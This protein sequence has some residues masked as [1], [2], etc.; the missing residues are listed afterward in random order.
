MKTDFYS[1]GR[2]SV[3]ICQTRSP[4]LLF[5][6][7]F[8][9]S[10]LDIYPNFHINKN[11]VM[12]KKICT[13]ILV[14]FYFLPTKAQSYLNESCAWYEFNGDVVDGYLFIS[15]RWIQGDTVMNGK[16]YWKLYNFTEYYQWG[17]MMNNLYSW[18][19]IREEDGAFYELVGSGDRFIISFDWE[20]GDTIPAMGGG[21][22]QVVAS[23]ETFEVAGEQR[24]KFITEWGF[25]IYEG[26]GTN[27][28][29]LEGLGFLGDESFGVL[30]CFSKDGDILE[31]STQTL[32]F[33]QIEP[34][35]SILMTST[36]QIPSPHP[37]T[38]IYPNPTTA[39]FHL[40]SPI[41]LEHAV[42]KLFDTSGR[43]QN[44]KVKSIQTNT[45]EFD[46]SPE[47]PP[48][49]YFL[50]IEQHGRVHWQKVVKQ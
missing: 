17:I 49:I 15:K 37:I 10:Y 5:S 19:L 12:A 7:A 18:G 45:M 25:E 26:I 29:L 11:T 22:P 6:F 30:R 46:F 9:E 40:T 44:I 2:K 43:T 42:F 38:T 31:L 28:G 8:D 1:F 50:S 36:Q 39:K 23:I 32:G 20:V 13:L 47:T 16:Q 14:L 4:I 24:K 3:F 41:D 33:E 35:D 48:G 34:C 27:Q 21:Y